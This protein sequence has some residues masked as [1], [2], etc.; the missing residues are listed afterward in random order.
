MRAPTAGGL[1]FFTQ[2]PRHC[3]PAE[4][5]ADTEPEV[6][7][8]L[9]VEAEAAPGAGSASSPSSAQAL[10][11]ECA[12]Q[13]PRAAGEQH[14]PWTGDGD[15]GRASSHDRRRTTTRRGP[16]SRAFPPWKQPLLTGNRKGTYKLW[17]KDSRIS[18]LRQTESVY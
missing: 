10:R 4:S 8:T 3:V 15:A 11:G 7:S 9:G 18:L 13:G 12:A 17:W 5:H 6:R 1:C 2:V 16:L 14:E